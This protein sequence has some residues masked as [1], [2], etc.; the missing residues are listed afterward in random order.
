MADD[1]VGSDAFAE[2]QR[3]LT[4]LVSP[5]LSGIVPQ[6]P[7]TYEKFRSS[8]YV[9]GATEL[10]HGNFIYNSYAGVD[11]VAQMI[12][13][14]NQPVA[15]GELQTISYSTHREN[16]PVRVLGHSSPISFVKGGRT[17]AGSMIF[18]V[19]NNYA[20]YRLEHF[21]SAV[22]KGL[23]PIADM[24]PP[25]DIVL[26]FA[27]EFGVFSK[28]KIYG[29]TFVDE[30][31]SMSIDDLISEQTFAYMARGIQPMTGYTIPGPRTQE[32]QSG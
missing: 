30:G 17:I 2:Y 20:F 27:N 11:I 22:D 28:M 4:S 26:T 10:R 12:L 18:T 15:M 3:N 8:S 13:P 25:V 1:Y 24:L 7:E 14:N 9:V 21:Q 16:L 32:A 23:Y 19:F 31:G 29:V 6:T 5:S